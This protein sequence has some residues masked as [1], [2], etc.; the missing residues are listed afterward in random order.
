MATRERCERCSRPL[1]GV[2]RWCVVHGDQVDFGAA[3]A[4]DEYS[5]AKGDV[6]PGEKRQKAKT[7]PGHAKK[8]RH[9]GL[10]VRRSEMES[11]MWLHGAPSSEQAEMEVTA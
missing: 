8:C 9:C 1:V 10:L 3:P 11:H 7:I 6:P 2:S 5:Y 4:V